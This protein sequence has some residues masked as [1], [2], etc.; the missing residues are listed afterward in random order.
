MSQC[1]IKYF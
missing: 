1:S